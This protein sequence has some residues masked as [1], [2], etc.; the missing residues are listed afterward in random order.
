MRGAAQRQLGEVGKRER[1]AALI[2]ERAPPDRGH[3]EIDDLGRGKLLSPDS[4]TCAVSVFAVITESSRE[5]ACVDD[6]HVTPRRQ[7]SCR[8]A[9]STNQARRVSQ[10]RRAS[11]APTRSREQLVER[12]SARVGDQAG[13]QVLLQGLAGGCGSLA[14]H[15]VNVRRH[16]LDLDTGHGLILAPI[17][18]QRM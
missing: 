12:R 9:V 17:W 2:R 3:L 10:S 18:R 15:G 6:Y 13:Q 14:Q 8:I 7:R 5:N 11:R 1:G 16:V 4:R